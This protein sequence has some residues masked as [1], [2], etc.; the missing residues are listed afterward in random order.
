MVLT[1]QN[2][3]LESDVVEQ[4][5]RPGGL[6]PAYVYLECGYAGP[7][8]SSAS[9]TAPAL[10]PEPRYEDTLDGYGDSLDAFSKPATFKLVVTVPVIGPVGAVVLTLMEL[11][12]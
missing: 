9:A 3:E 12:E 4:A 1:G 2:V 8:S 7:C 6:R 5:D 11:I 10:G